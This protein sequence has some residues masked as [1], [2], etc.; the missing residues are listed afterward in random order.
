MPDDRADEIVTDLMRSAWIVQQS[1]AE[2]FDRW[3]AR[4]SAAQA[5]AQAEILA[6]DLA[7]RSRKRDEDLVQAHA[8]WMMNLAGSKPGEEPFG[9]LFLCRLSDWVEA[10]ISPFL[11]DGGARLANLAEDERSQLTFP[12]KLP[13]PPPF[14]PIETPDLRPPSPVRFRFAIVGDTHFGSRHGEQAVRAAIKDINASGAE[15]VIQLGDLTEHGDKHEFE[16]AATVLAELNAPLVTMMGNHDVYSYR[17]ERLAGREHYPA[18]F[19]REPEGIILEHRG[20]KFGV[21]DSVEH[22]TSPFAPFDLFSGTFTDRKGGAI[23]RGT[24]TP[25]QHE[26]LADLASPGAGPAFIFLHHPVQPFTGFPPVVFGL[27]DEDSGRIHATCDSGNIW[28]IFAGHTHRNA[29]TRDFDGV[30]AQEVAIP[31]DFPFG[32][33][34]VDVSD[35]GYAYRF[36]QISDQQFLKRAYKRAGSIHR[37]YAL[38]SERERSFIWSKRRNP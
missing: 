23:V 6:D 3:G 13:Q 26:L 22:E 19:G 11:G 21:L 25:A 29:R 9:D 8:D 36:T 16:L 32:F 15:L 34:L 37:R 31:R 24:L 35:H 33:A 7:R 5:R 4:P 1:R 14:E 28:G 12:S 2:V 27:R 20:V 38:G 30:P 10:H 18:S 17:E